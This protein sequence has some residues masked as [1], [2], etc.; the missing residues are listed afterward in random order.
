[1][2]ARAGC[3]RSLPKDERETKEKKASVKQEGLFRALQLL[4][5]LLLSAASSYLGSKSPLRDGFLEDV[6][7][8]SAFELLDRFHC[9]VVKVM[10]NCISRNLLPE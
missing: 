4:W 1:M 8:T 10:C 9:K 6:Y 2:R 3:L 5:K 7:S